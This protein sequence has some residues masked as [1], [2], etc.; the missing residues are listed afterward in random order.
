[1]STRQDGIKILDFGIAKRVEQ[2]VLDLE[3]ALSRA[4]EAAKA[5]ARLETAADEEG[6]TMGT[7][8]L[9]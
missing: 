3:P 8:S 1:M 5:Q 9:G 4:R 6:D 7:S 2:L